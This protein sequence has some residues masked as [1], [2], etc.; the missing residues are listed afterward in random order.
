MK[1]T[2]VI[3][4]AGAMGAGKSAAA[5][6]LLARLRRSVWLDGDWCWRQG[7][8]WHF[9]EATKAMALDNIGHLL[10]NFAA[11]PNFDRIIFSWVLHLPE[12]WAALKE[13]LA[14]LPVVWKPVVLTCAEPELRRR[15][16]ARGG[17]RADVERARSRDAACR[18][19]PFPLLD[20][21]RLT[22]EETA[23]R[24]WEIAG[25]EENEWI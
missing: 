12:T 9:D 16:L 23:R 20:T 24:I 6:A 18:A 2:A 5:E 10:R 17:T 11:N 1:E 3:A 4:V 25:Q 7:R 21:T 15:I 14:G 19:L 13:A 8:D 22:A